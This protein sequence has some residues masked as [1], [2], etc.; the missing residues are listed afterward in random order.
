M[1]KEKSR[2]HRR[3]NSITKE[4]L[5][6]SLE[7]DL[8]YKECLELSNIISREIKDIIKQVR[9]PKIYQIDVSK[10]VSDLLIKEGS[11]NNT[12][13]TINPLATTQ[14]KIFKKEQNISSYDITNAIKKFNNNTNQ[15]TT[16][17]D[18]KLSTK[19][20][21]IY[22][23]YITSPS[24]QSVLPYPEGNT[25]SNTIKNV[26]ALIDEVEA[27]NESNTEY[28][29]IDDT[30]ED[31]KN[32]EEKDKTDSDSGLPPKLPDDYSSSL[33]SASTM[34]LTFSISSGSS[35][36]SKY[37]NHKKRM[38]KYSSSGKS[39]SSSPSSSPDASFIIKSASDVIKEN[40]NC[41]DSNLSI[42][43]ED[44]NDDKELND[45]F[46]TISPI[47]KDIKTP[48]KIHNNDD[49]DLIVNNAIK[50]LENSICK[51]NN[52][53]TNEIESSND[54][55]NEIE[56][57]NN[58]DNANEIKIENDND[59]TNEIEIENN[60]DN[61]NEIENNNDNANESN[62]DNAKEIESNN[63]NANEI[64]ID[65]DKEV[66]KELI[67]TNNNEKNTPS[68]SESEI[69]QT[70][71][72]IPFDN[73][74][75]DNFIK[76]DNEITIPENQIINK[77]TNDS[78]NNN[79][80]DV[81]KTTIENKIESNNITENKNDIN[82]TISHM[83]PNNNEDIPSVSVEVPENNNSNNNNDDDDDNH[84]DDIHSIHSNSTNSS[85]S[86]LSDFDIE[87]A[88]NTKM[89]HSLYH[90]AIPRSPSKSRIPTT[91][92]MKAMPSPSLLPKYTPGIS[93][94][95]SNPNFSLH[96][97]R[98][99]SSLSMV[100]NSPSFLP[101]YVAP[102][103]NH[104]TSTSSDKTFNK[105][106]SVDSIIIPPKNS[107][108]KKLNRLS[109][110]SIPASPRLSISSKFNSMPSSPRSNPA[111]KVAKHPPPAPSSYM[112]CRHNR[113]QSL[114]DNDLKLFKHKTSFEK[115]EKD[116]GNSSTQIPRHP[117][118]NNN[119]TKIPMSPQ[120]LSKR[121]SR[122]LSNSSMESLPLPPS[123]LPM[124]SST[125]SNNVIIHNKRK[126]LS[127]IPI[128]SP[129]SNASSPMFNNY[130]PSPKLSSSLPKTNFYSN[131]NLSTS[132]ISNMTESHRRIKSYSFTNYTNNYK[133]NNIS[134]EDQFS[135]NTLM[136]YKDDSSKKNY[137]VAPSVSSISSFSSQKSNDLNEML[138][139]YERRKIREKEMQYLQWIK[140]CLED[141]GEDDIYIDV[142]N[143]RLSN[144]LSDGIILAYLIEVTNLYHPICNNKNKNNN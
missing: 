79:T 73:N 34:S 117:S 132:D 39:P 8:L 85:I 37:S 101:V 45:V 122:T 65:N 76:N 68:D 96:N 60:N 12:E 46:S 103:L 52:D 36:N 16:D 3:S 28:Y 142:E 91:P 139:K 71:K 69:E 1:N 106:L 124:E 22:N 75:N 58:N 62:N 133:N 33:S 66:E 25:N 129:K 27:I 26:P 5:K 63:D 115:N 30:E 144:I 20:H 54:N 67:I 72:E 137:P 125:V 116:S 4:S 107:A 109:Y 123:S 128:P 38:N 108:S 81:T 95:I 6:K 17:Y 14:Y 43:D 13:E 130:M 98:P 9:N 121:H 74:S 57:E 93:N 7:N 49:N 118:F 87:E 61:A 92:S 51:E 80:D 40:N 94:K 2:I 97:R 136:Q 104:K 23:S 100:S 113:Y 21:G 90:K 44:I 32:D 15:N 138:K 110:D 114:N 119:Y 143:D 29:Y 77:N 140:E 126:S 48:D 102:K 50:K 78:E 99:S 19:K 70:I 89:E 134:Y 131:R 88:P 18:T 59:N 127:S 35:F 64:E 55:A 105:R 24:L 82:H 83:I 120:L 47:A 42:I 86:T 11:A 84:N 31:N 112:S 135:T 53:S 141:Y 41:P 56:I 10:P 111:K